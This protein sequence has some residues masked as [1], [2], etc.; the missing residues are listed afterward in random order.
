MT[1]PINGHPNFI[2]DTEATYSPINI[3]LLQP[4]HPFTLLQY[5]AAVMMKCHNLPHGLHL[6]KPLSV[7]LVPLTTTEAPTYFFQ[8]LN[9]NLGRFGFPLQFLSNPIDDLLP[10][11]AHFIS[12]TDTQIIYPKPLLI[13]TQ[14]YRDK[15]QLCKSQAHWLGHD[16]APKCKTLSTEHI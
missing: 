11:S 9:A 7:S 16:L 2:V 13:G 10:C 15:L 6:S 12:L 4:L 1:I 14:V 8:T 5:W 3:S